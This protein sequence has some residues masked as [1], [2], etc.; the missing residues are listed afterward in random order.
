MGTWYTNEASYLSDIT[1]IEIDLFDDLPLGDTT[2]TPLSRLSG[3]LIIEDQNGFYIDFIDGIYLTVT[4]VDE[5]HAFIFTSIGYNSI[6]GLFNLT[7]PGLYYVTGNVIFEILD[8]PGGNIISSYTYNIESASNFFIW[9]IVDDDL[10][11]PILNGYPDNSGAYIGVEKITLGNVSYAEKFID[12]NSLNSEETI[13]LETLDIKNEIFSNSIISEESF[14]KQIIYPKPYR[15]SIYIWNQ[16]L[17]TIET[18]LN[19]RLK[20]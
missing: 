7:G 13:I 10:P 8:A 19:K 12:P 20:S 2:P 15:G 1:N 3:S 16:R 6:G 14:K 18:E 4:N 11:N 9:Y 17:L 5:D